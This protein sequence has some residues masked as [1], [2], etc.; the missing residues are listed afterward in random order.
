ML[1]LKQ[2]PEQALPPEKA[3]TANLASFPQN[4]LPS[5]PLVLD[6]GIER[7]RV[8][9]YIALALVAGFALGWIASHYSDGNSKNGSV[10]TLKPIGD[11]RMAQS[12]PVTAPNGFHLVTEV[13]DGSTIKV[14]GVGTVRM[15]GIETPDGKEPK[16]IFGVHGQNAVN[17]VKGSLLG[18]QVRLEYNGADASGNKDKDGATL[19]YVYT[20]DGT[21]FNGEMIRQGH[22]FVATGAF[23]K[24]D[25]FRALQSQAMESMKGVWGPAE[26]STTAAT[27]K[28]AD[29]SSATGDHKSKKLAPALPPLADSK[30]DVL[31]GTPNDPV[32]YVSA[33]DRMYHKDG[34]AYLSKDKRRMLMSEAKSKGYVACGRCFASTVMKAQ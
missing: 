32:I 33:S 14:D 8:G 21:L 17:F 23:D 4:N 26:P 19:A 15:L 31:A 22:A 27:E 10:Y 9:V 29:P 3:N 11:Q 25:E 6:T 7:R 34:C 18:K 16:S 24:I 13:L 30:P 12:T 20:S 28:P 5:R 2:K 1:E